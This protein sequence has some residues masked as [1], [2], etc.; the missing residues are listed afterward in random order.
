MASPD[1]KWIAFSSAV[2]P[3]Y[4]DKPFKESNELNKKRKEENEK[5]PVKAK[6][7]TKLFFRH[8]DSYVEDKRQHLFVLK[9]AYAKHESPFAPDETKKWKPLDVVLTIKIAR[10][11]CVKL[12]S[13]IIIYAIMLRSWRQRLRKVSQRRNG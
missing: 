4:S 10:K 3:E 1:G 12:T 8:W 2:W 11:C 9:V 6:V 5:N 7:F 13:F